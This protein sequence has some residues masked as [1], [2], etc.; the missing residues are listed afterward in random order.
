VVLTAD[1]R[2]L[3]KGYHEKF[4]GPH[5][6]INALKGLSLDQ[7]KGARLFVTLEPCA[8]EGKTPSCAKYLTTL[9]LYSV[10]YGLTDPNPLVSGKG[11]SILEAA[12]IKT[13]LFDHK[14]NEL[15][16][17]CE[18]FLKNHIEKKVFVSLKV[19]TSLDGMLSFK[20][21][22]SKWITGEVARIESHFLRACHDGILIGARTLKIDDPLLDIRHPQFSDKTNKVIILDPTADS[23]RTLLNQRVLQSHKPENIIVVVSDQTSQDVVQKLEVSSL[24]GVKIL[25]AK[26]E[27]GLLDLQDVLS[28]LW[29]L[30][31]CSIL[32]EGGAFTHS[33]FIRQKCADRLYQFMAPKIIGGAAG[34]VWTDHLSISEMSQAIQLKNLKSRMMGGDIFIT[35]IF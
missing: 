6:E 7:L 31:I 23:L 28:K 32:V 20:T 24:L 3:S 19:A 30:D 8:H 34:K 10:T 35:G 4:G 21:G 5:A 11:A 25:R 14:K 26:Q 9:P 33:E 18:V 17:V 13:I 12:G 29:D 15:K 27:K 2:F 16:E 1:H 22:E